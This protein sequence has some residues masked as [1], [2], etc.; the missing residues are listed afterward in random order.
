[1]Q[2]RSPGRDIRQPGETEFGEL[3]ARKSGNR[4]AHVLHRLLALL[5]G[6]DHFFEKLR[7]RARH[8]K[9]QHDA[10]QQAGRYGDRERSGCLVET[11]PTS[12]GG[13]A[14][15]ECYEGVVTLC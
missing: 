14:K 6:D 13:D 1:M 11:C 5:G 3:I 9:R 4:D 7:R 10:N 2:P 8:R 15:K 12:S